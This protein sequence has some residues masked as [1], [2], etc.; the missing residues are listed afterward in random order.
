MKKRIIKYLVTLACGF[1]GIAIII[2]AKD[3]F[4]QTEKVNIFH[5]LCDACFAVGVV[6]TSM[7]LL[8]FASNEGTFD[9]L[10]YGVGSFFNMFRKP[11]KRKY[12]TL[13]DYKEA[14]SGKKIRF[15]FLL[16]CGLLFLA[17]ALLM[18]VFYRVA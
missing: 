8:M 5:I 10:I 3:I 9:G 16:I 18:Y 4:S 2:F 12:K 7:G 6:I 13:Y 1:A 15:G 17:I 11:E 14:R